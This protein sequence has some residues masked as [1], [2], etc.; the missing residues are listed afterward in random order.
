MKNE[1][2]TQNVPSGYLWQ[3]L[4]PVQTSILPTFI[5]F[6][7]S[8]CHS[9][10]NKQNLI[11]RLSTKRQ[12][13]YLKAAPNKLNF[14]LFAIP[15]CCNLCRAVTKGHNPILITPVMAE[16]TWLLRVSVSVRLVLHYT[17]MCISLLCV[18]TLI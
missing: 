9:P 1:S 2:F 12:P 17:C 7:G 13:A 18:I 5:K 10:S 11:S 3:K 16:F 6:V 4:T 8:S 15:D 14:C